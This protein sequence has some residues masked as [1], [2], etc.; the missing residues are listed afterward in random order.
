MAS[1]DAPLASE[2]GL[3]TFDSTPAMSTKSNGSR[4]AVLGLAVLG[5][6]EPQ[7]GANVQELAPVDHG[8]GA[9]S[10]CACG[11]IAEMFIWGFLFR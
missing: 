2:Y 3:S 4:L 8:F 9:W 5:R 10:F 7:E 1:G 6:S 11:F